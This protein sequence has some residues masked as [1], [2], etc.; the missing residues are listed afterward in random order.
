[1]S[2][3]YF[4]RHAE[5]VF[6]CLGFCL[7]LEPDLSRT[8]C[9][10]GMVAIR[11][12]WHGNTQE[13]QCACEGARH[14]GEYMRLDQRSYGEYLSLLR[15]LPTEEYRDA[16][17]QK[18]RANLL[19]LGKTK[20]LRDEMKFRRHGEHRNSVIQPLRNCYVSLYS[21]HRSDRR[22]FLSDGYL[23]SQR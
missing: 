17:L 18:N 20:T 7:Y 1:M 10:A 16:A 11:R 15:N 12:A 14:M 2:S 19:V 6:R 9:W 8:N 23:Y 21:C 22:R 13:A 5:Y 3:S 4:A